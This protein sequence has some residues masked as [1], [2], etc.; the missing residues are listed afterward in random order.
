MY[1]TTTFVEIKTRRRPPR[2]E[3]QDFRKKN[4]VSTQTHFVLRNKS[5]EGRRA[6][7]FCQTI[8][9]RKRIRSGP[10]GNIRSGPGGNRR[11]VPTYSLIYLACPLIYVISVF[12]NIF[13]Q[14]YPDFYYILA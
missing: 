8:L 1:N 6:Q 10:G 11:S 14:I 13:D 9:T 3:A 12:C 2:T 7:D 5:A 4:V